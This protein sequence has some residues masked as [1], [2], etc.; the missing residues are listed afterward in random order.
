MNKTDW[1]FIWKNAWRRQGP[2][3]WSREN[4]PLMTFVAQ[5]NASGFPRLFGLFLTLSADVVYDRISAPLLR[6]GMKGL[7]L[8]AKPYSLTWL[9]RRGADITNS[10]RWWLERHAVAFA[11]YNR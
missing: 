7:G 2:P 4:T 6:R 5:S 11:R 8:D 3:S 1:R 9:A 10:F